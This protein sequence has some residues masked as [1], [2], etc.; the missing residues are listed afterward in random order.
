MSRVVVIG[1]GAMGLRPAIMPPSAATPSPCSKPRPSR[2]AWR[3]ISTSAAC[4]SS[5]TYHFVCKSDR[6]T[7]DLLAE[8]G[9]GDKMRWVPTS[10]GYYV[11]GTLYRWGDPVALLQFPKLSLIEKLRYGAMMFLVDQAQRLAAASKTSRPRTGSP[12]GAGAASM[13]VCGRRCSS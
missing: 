7:F 10:M 13:S 11:D 9:L 2:A 3:R 8:L 4:R 6:A 12:P 1:A 5:A